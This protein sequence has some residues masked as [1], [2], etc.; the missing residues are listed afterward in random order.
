MFAHRASPP[1]RLARGYRYLWYWSGSYGDHGQETTWVY[2]RSCAD[3][4]ANWPVLVI[5]I[6]DALGVAADEGRGEDGEQES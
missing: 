3:P 5:R 4:D 2:N 6:T 1:A